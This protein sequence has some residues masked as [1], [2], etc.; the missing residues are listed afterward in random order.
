VPKALIVA[1]CFASD[2]EA[3][4]KLEAELENVTARITVM[5]EEQGGEEGVLSEL[6]KLNKANV[7]ARLKEIKGDVDAKEEIA[8][9]DDWLKLND[10]EADLKKRLKEAEVALD[11]KAYAQYPKLSEVEIQTLAVDDKWLRARCCYPW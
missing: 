10:E 6:D 1:R 2:Q 3:I 9:L 11:A 8:V 7:T 5:E 4:I